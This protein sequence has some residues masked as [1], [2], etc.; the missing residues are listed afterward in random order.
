MQLR[1]RDHRLAGAGVRRV[2]RPRRTFFFESDGTAPFK[3]GMVIIASPLDLLP[4][5]SSLSL[6]EPQSVIQIIQYVLR[7][8]R[9]QVYNQGRDVSW[10]LY[11]C[12]YGLFRTNN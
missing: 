11:G 8:I 1:S 2:P 6:S 4:L 3:D 12:L 7:P 5:F 10:L 9:E